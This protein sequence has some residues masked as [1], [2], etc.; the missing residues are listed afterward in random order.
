MQPVPDDEIVALLSLPL[1][2]F[3]AARDA[4]AR[5]LRASGRREEAAALAKVRKP[6]RPVWALGQLGRERPEQVARAV[7]VADRLAAVQAGGA[8]GIAVEPTLAAPL[9]P[10]ERQRAGRRW[11]ASDSE[12]GRSPRSQSGEG[13][14]R[15]LLVE[16]RAVSAELTAGLGG[17]GGHQP[18]E[19]ALVLRTVLGDAD[20]R[21]AWA[22][23]RLLALPA[24]P[25][26]GGL[27]DD[28]RPA[29][30]GG[31]TVVRRP[32]PP[33][34]VRPAHPDRDAVAPPAPETAPGD[35][36]TAVAE[37]RA[38]QRRRVEER[39]RA[40]AAVAPARKVLAEA[41]RRQQ[42]ARA[43]LASLEARL[44]TLEAEVDKA[45]TEAHF[46][47]RAVADAGVALSTAVDSAR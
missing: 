26:L 23:G 18:A 42:T 1:D 6:L 24:G 2:R 16:L 29:E 15:A 39:R 7:A 9:R 19:T 34:A 32:L 44:A 14:T 37:R 5:E 35:G 33:A 40:K 17:D 12:R 13:D 4:R 31:Q 20:A 22:D 28:G 27:G 30:V 38:E 47:D 25:G 41:E 3:V 36:P 43:R 46:A 21:R 8:G 45:R 10:S 11:G